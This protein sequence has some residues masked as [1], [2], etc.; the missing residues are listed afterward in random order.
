LLFTLI[1]HHVCG[2]MIAPQR[3]QRISSS[4]IEHL[5]SSRLMWF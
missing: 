3:S 2:V 4:C 5:A 1:C